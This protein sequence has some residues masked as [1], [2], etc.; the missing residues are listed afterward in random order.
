MMGDYHPYHYPLTGILGIPWGGGSLGLLCGC[1]LG[2]IHPTP[3]GVI[4]LNDTTIYQQA[5]SASVLE[6]GRLAIARVV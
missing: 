1:G 3:R 6:V 5:P 2:T 4:T